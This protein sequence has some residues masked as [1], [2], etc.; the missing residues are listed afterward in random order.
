MMKVV[1]IM[2]PAS[3]SVPGRW[4]ASLSSPMMRLPSNVPWRCRLICQASAAAVVGA[5]SPL[6]RTRRF[7][8]YL[9]TVL[10]QV[11]SAVH[12]ARAWMIRCSWVCF[13][14]AARFSTSFQNCSR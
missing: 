1:W 5:L 7:A 14:S 12:R 9:K 2:S 11:Y 3:G 6:G 8:G 13:C 10:C 4:I